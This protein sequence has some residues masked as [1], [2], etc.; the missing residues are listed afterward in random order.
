MFYLQ[1]VKYRLRGHHTVQNNSLWLDT[2]RIRMCYA[3]NALLSRHERHFII[4]TSRVHHKAQPYPFP[5][6]GGVATTGS[7][8]GCR[9]ISPSIVTFGVNSIVLPY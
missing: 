1:K 5:G 2:L 4:I 6:G 7:N 3:N 8:Q 9:L